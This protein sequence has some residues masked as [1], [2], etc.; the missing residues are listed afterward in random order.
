MEKAVFE[1]AKQPFSPVNIIN[2][3]YQRTGIF[4]N[5]E[6]TTLLMLDSQNLSEQFVIDQIKFEKNIDSLA[7]HTINFTTEESK[8][9][10]AYLP[11]LGLKTSKKT[12]NGW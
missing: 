1:K 8:L 4:E 12:M 5:Y 9:T 10:K 11:Q 2:E 3:L 6:L 7:D